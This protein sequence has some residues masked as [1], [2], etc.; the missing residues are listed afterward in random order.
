MARLKK[1][2]GGAC[3]FAVDLI[4]KSHEQLTGGEF[5]SSMFLDAWWVSCFPTSWLSI[6]F[7]CAFAR[8]CALHDKC[9]M[10]ERSLLYYFNIRE[11]LD[12]S[13]QSI[14]HRPFLQSCA[15]H[16]LQILWRIKMCLS[17]KQ[18]LVN[19]GKCVVAEQRELWFIIT[20]QLY[21]CAMWLDGVT[22]WKTWITLIALLL[23]CGLKSCHYDFNEA[24]ATEK[25]RALL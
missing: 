19:I 6:I 16:L 7:I 21:K 25:A 15:H 20:Y 2:S 8:S 10:T 23:P 22:C 18:R 14:V 13:F 12:N 17:M 5:S 3:S 4:M 24:N 9:D 1:H 11:T